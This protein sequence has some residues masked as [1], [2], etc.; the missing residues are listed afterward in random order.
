MIGKINTASAKTETTASKIATF[1]ENDSRQLK[2]SESTPL[3]SARGVK[4]TDE[5][6]GL[7]W[8]GPNLPLSDEVIAASSSMIAIM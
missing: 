5:M 7:P 4:Q 8:P 6:R 1:G 3:P 2:M